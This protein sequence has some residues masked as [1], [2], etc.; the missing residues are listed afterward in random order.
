MSRSKWKFQPNLC[1][2]GEMKLWRAKANRAKRRV[3]NALLASG[4]YDL[5][6]HDKEFCNEWG[7]PR[8]GIKGYYTTDQ[9]SLRK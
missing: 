9:K 1:A 6:P 3:V 2:P 7:T 5:M 8:D 4:E